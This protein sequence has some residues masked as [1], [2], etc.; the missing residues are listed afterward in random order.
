MAINLLQIMLENE[1]G[2]LSENGELT[3]EVL[4]AVTDGASWR[5]AGLFL[6]ALASAA[7]SQTGAYT[8]CCFM[9]AAALLT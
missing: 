7:C 9:V 5:M 8:F 1:K 2:M 6:G 4:E 3:T